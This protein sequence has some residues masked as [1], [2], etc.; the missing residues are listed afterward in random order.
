MGEKEYIKECNQHA[1]VEGIPSVFRRKYDVD[2]MPVR[3]EVC[4]KIWFG[5]KVAAANFKKLLKGLELAT[6]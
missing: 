4:Q 1:G 6:S 2:E 5:L 3:G